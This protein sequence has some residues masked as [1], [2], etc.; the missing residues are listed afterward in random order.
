MNIYTQK[1]Y[2]IQ[3]LLHLNNPYDC[4]DYVDHK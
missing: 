4:Y 3:Q 1:G 2:S